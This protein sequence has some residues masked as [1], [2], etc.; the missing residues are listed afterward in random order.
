MKTGTQRENL[1]IVTE[2]LAELPGQWLRQQCEAAWCAPNEDDFERLLARA[3]GLVVRTYTTVDESLIR[4]APALRV[5]ARAGVGYDNID[6]A[7]CRARGITVLNRPGA[8]TGAVVEFVLARLFEAIRPVTEV[9]AAL[10]RAAWTA[11]RDAAVTERELSEMTVGILGFGRIGRRLAAA[12]APLGPSVLYHDL[13]EI[14][15]AECHGARRVDQATLVASSDVLSIHVDGRP[16]NR[17]LVD[18]TLLSHLREG[19]ILINTSRGFV[20]DKPALAEALRARPAA[21]ALLDVHEPEPIPADD[22]LLSIPGA[23][24]FP[25]VAGRTETALENMSWVV[26]D[27]VSVLDGGEPEFEVLA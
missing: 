19:A 18:G 17:G 26:R 1:V 8:N 7:A 21:R 6:V 16:G 14:P 13:L 10:P 2:A 12:L 5:V 22:P 3:E 9:H 4:R 24:L 20:V 15:A 27:L 23:H 25:H 11:L